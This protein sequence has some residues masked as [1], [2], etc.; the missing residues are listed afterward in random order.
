MADLDLP[1]RQLL[2]KKY[3]RDKLVALAEIQS[4][5]IRILEVEIEKEN[6]RKQIEKF[7]QQLA[8]MVNTNQDPKNVLA[9]KRFERD[10][11]NVL[12]HIQ[13]LE[14]RL[15]EFDE[16]I[17]R[18]QFDLEAQ[19]KQIAFLEMNIKQQQDLISQGK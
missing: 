4:R 11:T 16:E 13:S 3:G 7:Q 17:Q 5:E 8:G 18:C 2:I 10:R 9:D 19:K 14:I 15:L 12:I 1:S 6:Q